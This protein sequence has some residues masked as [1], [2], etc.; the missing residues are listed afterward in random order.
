MTFVDHPDLLADLAGDPTEELSIVALDV[1]GVIVG[2]A[3]GAPSTDAASSPAS[4]SSLYVEEDVAAGLPGRDLHQ[5]TLGAEVVRDAWC[6]RRDGTRYWA[7]AILRA[8]H[9]LDGRLAGFVRIAVDLTDQLRLRQRLAASEQRLAGLVE[10][11]ADGIV[12]TD[13]DGRIL[14]FNRGAELLF[15]YDRAE[16]IGERVE[17]LI[18]ER[19]RRAHEDHVKGFLRLPEGSSSMAGGRVV[20]ALTRDGREF[21]VEASIAKVSLAEGDILSVILRDAT[22]RIEV[23]RNLRDSLTA[24]QS[25]ADALPMPV[26]LIDHE[27]RYVFGNAAAAEWMGRAP[28]ELCGLS[29]RDAVR[30]ID[31]EASLDA[32]LPA[33]RAALRG[34]PGTFTGRVRHAD[35]DLRDVEVTLIPS[36]QPSGAVDGLFAVTI[37]LTEGRRG[38]LFRAL[39]AAASRLAAI[40]I[41]PGLLLHG[42]VL[43]ASS[44]FADRCAG[45]LKEPDGRVVRVGGHEARR[46]RMGTP[47]ARSDLP[48]GL[49]QALSHG[50]LCAY[51]DRKWRTTNICVPLRCEERPDG[52]LCFSW[53]APADVGVHE[54]E[55]AELLAARVAASM[56]HIELSRRSEEAIRGRDWLLRKVTHDLGNP[57][58]SLVMVLDRLLRLAPDPDRRVASRGFLEGAAQQA[59]EMQMIIEELLDATSIRV[60]RPALG[61]SRTD[62]RIAVRKAASLMGPMGDARG[63]AI[64][65]VEPTAAPAVM[66]D[67]LRLRRAL[68]ALISNAIAWSTEGGRIRVELSAVGGDAVRFAVVGPGPDISADDL[69]SLLDEGEGTR[70]GGVEMG[71][72]VSL[73]LVIA[74]EIVRAHGSRLEVSRGGDGLASYAFVLPAVA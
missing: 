10:R 16:V 27:L 39:Q 1:D 65:V 74:T 60:G 52:L 15:G 32:A 5:A 71:S 58:A 66:A 56:D 64:E 49:R 9:D 36:R 11:A 54:I 62:P 69:A 18:P 4:L 48:M 2:A 70:T 38:E 20:T 35:G 26:T 6:R 34:T 7:R 3:G 41:D 59:R 43:L 73:P 40:A 25:I 47:L 42:V 29:L 55:I 30:R 72:F 37:D 44:G 8:R 23:E 68:T 46:G 31:T 51:S 17:I 21:P 53:N 33:L 67:P 14:L 45:Y 22:H 12:S 19:F 24:V 57:V 63:V 50:R 61:R 13:A 28:E